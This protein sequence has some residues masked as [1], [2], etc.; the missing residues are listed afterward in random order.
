MSSAVTRRPP[1]SAWSSR[2]CFAV[3]H[4]TSACSAWIHPRRRTDVSHRERS[5]GFRA[6]RPAATVFYEWGVQAS[7]YAT[8]TL[9]DRTVRIVVD[10]QVDRRGSYGRLV[11]YLSVDG[12]QCNKQLLRQGYA[13]LYDSTFTKYDAF[14]DREA[15]AQAADRGRWNLEPRQTTVPLPTTTNT[16][17]D[18]PPPPPSGDYDCSHFDTQEQANK[19]LHRHPGDLLG[20]SHTVAIAP[21]SHIAKIFCV[22]LND[23][24]RT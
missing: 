18:V 7:T 23:I 10:E 19:G 20:H 1:D 2:C 22:R 21:Y 6:R 15:R 24:A 8:R 4:L 12:E 9:E 14:A 17:V 11:V 16:D 13:R 3:S 5:R